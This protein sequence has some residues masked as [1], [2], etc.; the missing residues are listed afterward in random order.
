MIGVISHAS[1]PHAAVVLDRLRSAGASA[2]LLDTADLPSRAA[3]TSTQDPETGWAGTWQGSHGEVALGDLHAMW[4]RRPQPFT[5]DERITRGQD[6][7]FALGETAAMVAGLWSCLEAHWVNDPVRDEAASAKMLQ[8]KRAREC[9]LSIPRTCMTNDP[10]RAREFLESVSGRAV[11]KPFSATPSTWRETRPV[12]AEDEALLDTVALAPVIFQERI[13]GGVD[14]R[15]TV[16]GSRQFP[17]RI[18]VSDPRFEFDV[19][20]DTDA[21]RITTCD[22]PSDVAAGLGRLMHSLGIVYGAADFRVTAD[23]EL[24][25]LEVNPAGQWLFVEMETGQPISAALADHLLAADR[26]RSGQQAERGETEEPP[27]LEPSDRTVPGGGG[28]PDQVGAQGSTEHTP[29]GQQDR[30]AVRQR[31]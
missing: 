8:L 16:V 9:G 29:D 5:V 23:G 31:G 25:F 10:A 28:R 3:L 6:Q 11:F 4:W 2:V 19:R 20:L 26:A 1:D 15:V 18:E 13:D 12:R 22:L 27:H 17:A 14:V 21:A 7:H 30:D 24:K